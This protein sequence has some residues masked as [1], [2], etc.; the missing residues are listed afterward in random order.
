[1]LQLIIG[2]VVVVEIFQ[3]N[4][5]FLAFVDGM[6]SLIE[7]SSFPIVGD[8]LVMCRACIDEPGKHELDK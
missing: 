2:I 4:Y 5:L 8:R 7:L 1:V 3:K 6:A